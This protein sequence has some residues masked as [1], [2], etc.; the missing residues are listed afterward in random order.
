[1]PSPEHTQAEDL[2]HESS[3]GDEGSNELLDRL[4]NVGQRV[5]DFVVE[6]PLTAV[7]LAVGVGFLFGRMMRR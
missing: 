7:A 1:M 5:T 3:H 4:E 6:R 2:E